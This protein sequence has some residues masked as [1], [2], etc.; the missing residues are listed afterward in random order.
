MQIVLALSEE[1]VQDLMLLRLLYHSKRSQLR[2]ERRQLVNQMSVV[3]DQ[4]PHP[5]QHVVEMTNLSTLLKDNSRENH[6]LFYRIA[7]VVYRGVG[8]RKTGCIVSVISYISGHCTYTALVG[9]HVLYLHCIND[10]CCLHVETITHHCGITWQYRAVP[11]CH[12]YELSDLR[13]TVCCSCSRPGSQQ[14]LLCTP[15]PTCP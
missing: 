3:E 12:R 5:C 9:I 15:T 8:D 10:T 1:Q 6:Q 14:T 2:Q 4:C 7:R 13:G 11:L